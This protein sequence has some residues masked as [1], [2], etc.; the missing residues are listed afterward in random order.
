MQKLL[1]FCLVLPQSSLK[2]ESPVSALRYIRWRLCIIYLLLEV[3]DKPVVAGASTFAHEPHEDSQYSV[4]CSLT[5]VSR[6]KGLAV[7]QQWIMI[8]NVFAL[9]L[10]I[11]SAPI[12][13]HFHKVQRRALC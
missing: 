9:L 3:Y 11:L 8:G 13:Q 2:A 12:T 4:S 10:P 6:P 7:I 5:I 1:L